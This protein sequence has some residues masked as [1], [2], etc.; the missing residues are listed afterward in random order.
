M[1]FLHSQKPA[2]LHRDLK[3]P[4]IFVEKDFTA[5]S[6]GD[7]NL[8]KDTESTHVSGAV[9][10]SNPM[11]LAPEVGKGISDFTVAADIY[12]FGILMWEILLN[13]TPWDHL[14]AA[15]G[16]GREIFFGRIR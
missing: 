8:S 7:F 4:N 1:I 2:I 12:A 11:W 13:R 3:S 14:K 6:V 10:P 9:R 16:M 15:P 5:A